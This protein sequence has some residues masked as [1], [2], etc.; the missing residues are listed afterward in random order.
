MDSQLENACNLP[1][2]TAMLSWEEGWVCCKSQAYWICVKRCIEL[3]VPLFGSFP[4]GL[5]ALSAQKNIFFKCYQRS[6]LA[7]CLL[8]T[9]DCKG[10]YRRRYFIGNPTQ[11]CILF[12]IGIVSTCET[13]DGFFQ[14]MITFSSSG[15]TAKHW[16]N[17][18]QQLTFEPQADFE[19]NFQKDSGRR[20]L[21]V[22]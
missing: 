15:R 6:I 19:E 12:Y 22:W 17:C 18:R 10:S 1:L 16:L 9:E 13:W 2:D 7:F 14:K 5:S 8:F 21:D 3:C 20:S 4:T 11:W